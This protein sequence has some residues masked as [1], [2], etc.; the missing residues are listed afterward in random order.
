MAK[1]L[2]D[3]SYL[4]NEKA[5]EQL[6]SSLR[7]DKAFVLKCL[8][9]NGHLYS[10][11]SPELKF[12]EH[13]IFQAIQQDEGVYSLLPKQFQSDLPFIQK[14]VELNFLVY[15]LLPIEIRS[16]RGLVFRALVEEGIDA[17]WEMPKSIFQDVEIMVTAFKSH[18]GTDEDLWDSI[19]C[20]AGDESESSKKLIQ[21]GYEIYGERVLSM[22]YSMLIHDQSII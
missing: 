4:Y 3:Q 18:N 7:S 9:R 10:L 2:S 21:R 5:F 17:L 1:Y 15:S 11:L 20:A 8:A 6:P 16:C 22:S 19:L 12:D 14:L 13:I